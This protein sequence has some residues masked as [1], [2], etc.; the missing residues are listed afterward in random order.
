[1]TNKEIIDIAQSF[2]VKDIDSIKN[3]G[4]VFTPYHIAD[5]I[6]R[7]T[8]PTITD[9]ICEPS[10]GKGIFIFA[11]IDY[12]LEKYKIEE[13]VNFIETKLHCFDINNDYIT[14]LKS[15]ICQYFSNIDYFNNIDLTNIKC[16]DFLESNGTYDIIFGNP[17]YVKIHNI[18]KDK[19]ELL[20]DKYKSLTL[21][22]VDL[23]Y[24][25]VEKSLK[26]SNVIGFIIPNTF[27]KNKSGQ[28]LREILIDRV[29]EIV[30]FNNNKI[31][32]NI[33]TYTCIITCNQLLTQKIIYN[34]N[35]YD[36]SI[37]NDDKWVFNNSTD[38]NNSL[39]DLI[40]Y[41]SIGIQ[42]SAD[43]YY[44]FKKFDTNYA[45]INGHKIELGICKKIIKA[46]KSKSF[47]DNNYV[48]YP[49]DDDNN[50]ISEDI[51]EK[52]YPQCYNYLLSI[53]NE[54]LKRNLNHDIW[55]IYGRNQGL[56]K[57]KM[58]TQIILPNTFLKSRNV[59]Y[60]KI[61]NNEDCLI[62]NGLLVDTNDLE[63]F[64]NIIQS[65][66]FLLYLEKNNKTLPDKQGSDDCWLTITA[67]SLKNYKY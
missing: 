2:D 53:K 65:E 36:K 21:G 43:K 17:P 58:D 8:C 5:Q 47:N 41:S 4:V 25:F 60:I 3:N 20:K 57:N 12:F 26:E 22:N 45:Y 51:I 55:Y 62:Q 15:L 35:I 56:I 24:A 44:I 33:S 52:T 39:N 54:L 49:Y 38:D 61:P 31:W 48:L 59:H 40:N 63:K 46:T 67:N 30:D 9:T 27:I 29:N 1:M 66:K 42:T 7:K 64:I 50:P 34:D 23:Y 6:I 28:Y 16:Q 19:L 11:L 14:E 18:G 32:S 13:V 37:L 10:V